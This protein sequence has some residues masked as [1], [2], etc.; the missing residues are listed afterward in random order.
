MYTVNNAKKYVYM[1]PECKNSV[2]F[3]L[4]STLKFSNPG[5]DDLNKLI[6]FIHIEGV[7]MNV[8]CPNCWVDMIQLDELIAPAVLKINRDARLSLDVRTTMSCQ[9]HYNDWFAMDNDECGLSTSGPWIDVVYDDELYHKLMKLRDEFVKSDATCRTLHVNIDINPLYLGEEPSTGEQKVNTI[10]ILCYDDVLTSEIR[11]D[12]DTHIK[13][14]PTVPD[15]VTIEH[16]NAHRMLAINTF[17]SF[18]DYV[19]DNYHK[20]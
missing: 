19:L 10:R 9:G 11:Y 1:C 15:L 12:D 8:M 4:E 7:D 18:I 6:R 13:S 14:H 17:T 5:V 16:Y 3:D 2:T 20:S